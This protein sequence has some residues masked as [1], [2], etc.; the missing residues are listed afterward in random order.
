MVNYESEKANP[1]PIDETPL[2][3]AGKGHPPYP[4]PTYRFVLLLLCKV[5]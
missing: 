2:I 1:S 3:K 5:I 4:F